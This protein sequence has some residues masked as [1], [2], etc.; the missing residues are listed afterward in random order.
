VRG[1]VTPA[2]VVLYFM[3]VR[4]SDRLTWLVVGGAVAWLLLLVVLVNG[5]LVIRGPG[6]WDRAAPRASVCGTSRVRLR[7]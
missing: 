4:W 5:D 2:L 3:H 7:E 6:Y 1:I